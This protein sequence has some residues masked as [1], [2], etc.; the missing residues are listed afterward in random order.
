VARLGRS[1]AARPTYLVGAVAADI[2]ISGSGIDSAEAFGG[3]VVAP[4]AVAL[5]GSGIATAEAL[6]AGVVQPGAVGLS[7]A[8][9]ASSEAFGTGT[10][11]VGA[12]TLSG[13]GIASG[14]LLGNG[15]VG[16]GAGEIL[17]AGI[18]S[19]EAFGA[20][21]VEASSAYEAAV[22][23][24]APFAYW[25][26]GE[27]SGTVAQD[28][29]VNNRDGTYVNTPTLGAAGALVD[30]PADAA[31]SFAAA[32]S[33]R[34]DTSVLTG[35]GASLATASVEFWIKTTA[36]AQQAVLGALNTGTATMLQVLL[37]SNE[38]G[39]L[40]AGS[41]AVTVRDQGGKAITLRIDRPIYDGAWHHVVF[42]VTDPAANVITAYV[43]GEQVSGV[44]ATGGGGAPNNFA[45]FGFQMPFG[46]RNNRGTVDLFMDGTLDEVAI[47]TTRLSAGR[48][49]A[50]YEAAG[51]AVGATLGG[52]GVPSAEVFGS[53]TVTAGAVTL[54]G[55]GVASAE[56][57]G[58]GTVGAGQIVGA[59]IPSAEALGSG[60]VA[61]GAVTLAGVGIASGGALGSGVVAFGA[62]QLAGAGVASAEALGTGA[63]APGAA[64]LV[65]A[66]IASGET[67]G[68]GVVTLV[69]IVRLAGP[70]GGVGRAPVGGIMP[71]VI[72]GGG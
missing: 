5:T 7:G 64:E 6:G 68:A 37:N 71:T 67:L 39:A 47:Y 33:E 61:P 66:G 30:D 40:L 16:A 15:I 23:A 46:A 4:G 29:T 53:G 70:A 31:V 55:T 25:R 2:T 72:G 45:N 57:L 17:G 62:A 11:G 63:V 49:V 44:T 38:A 18:P 28:E 51:Y 36:A 21:A 56:A 42:V 12:V 26:V 9:I 14:E 65:G 24:D 1:Y 27:A 54:A 32:Q 60:A 19:A 50:H 8:G 13:A 3:G 22:L 34:V 58:V 35:F 43:D 69:S 52:A 10:L 59:G 48:V 20:G 41:T